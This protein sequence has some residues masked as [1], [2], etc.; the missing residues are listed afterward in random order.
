M[1]KY[2]Y[3]YMDVKFKAHKWSTQLK[4]SVCM[5]QWWSKKT[6]KYMLD[7]LVFG[8]CLNMKKFIKIFF[9]Y[10]IEMTF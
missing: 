5:Y 2:S 1:E 7:N 9:L 6:L 10:E 3:K 8:K 4:I